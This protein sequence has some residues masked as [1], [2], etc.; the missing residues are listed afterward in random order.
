MPPKRNRPPNA[1]RRARAGRPTRAEEK[2]ARLAAAEAEQAERRRRARRRLVWIIV[3]VV[4]ALTAIV[5][6]DAYVLSHAKKHGAALGRLPDVGAAPY[7]KDHAPGV[8][9]VP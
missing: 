7:A 3:A 9:S 1:S 8:A 2:R 4:L 5:L 6:V